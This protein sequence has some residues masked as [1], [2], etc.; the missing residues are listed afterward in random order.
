LIGETTLPFDYVTVG[1]L[2]VQFVGW[3][4]RFFTSIRLWRD[5]ELKDSIL[6]YMIEHR[7]PK[8]AN[9]IWLHVSLEPIVGDVPF[10]IAFPPSYHGWE[11]F[12]FWFKK[13]MYEARHQWRMYWNFVPERRVQKAMRELR[14][15][16]QL[17]L[18]A[19]QGEFYRLPTS[20]GT[21]SQSAS[22]M[23]E[24][25]H[26]VRAWFATVAFFFGLILG[27]IGTYFFL[28]QR[29]SSV[30]T[31]W[32]ELVLDGSGFGW[33]SEA[34][35]NVDIPLP[36]VNKPHGQ[37]KFLD[38]SQSGKENILLG[39]VVKASVEHL[40]TSKIPPKYRQPK[41]QGE[42]VI[43][44]P[45]EVVYLAHLEFTLKDADGFVLL[46]TDTEPLHLYSGKENV[47]QGIA[48]TPV[49]LGTAKRTSSILVALTA[50]KC[51]TC[52]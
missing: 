15:Q 22:A 28:P 14:S 18:T 25:P 5:K 39:Y 24:T 32:R 31:K 11:R 50:D 12:K 49:S 29:H 4:S 16:G 44:P 48:L 21:S 38:R 45:T 35:F 36:T 51:E 27:M 13:V 42:F 26:M 20:T 7:E 8:N 23:K 3:L 6:D 17:E 52:E 41:K 10:S 34:L 46:T 43:D 37:A 33:K 1:K 30:P 47:F 2:I 40:D 9:S 19:L